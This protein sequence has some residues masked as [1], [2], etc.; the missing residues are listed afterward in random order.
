MKTNLLF[1]ITKLHI[2]IKSVQNNTNIKNGISKHYNQFAVSESNA[3]QYFSGI[4]I[5]YII[6]LYT[7]LTKPS[8][9]FVL[10]RCSTIAT[11]IKKIDSGEG[12]NYLNESSY[13]GLK[14]EMG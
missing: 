9:S 7:N 14:L 10:I 5:N 4:K 1:L 8:D 13:S 2:R 6:K 12:P 11:Q 3:L